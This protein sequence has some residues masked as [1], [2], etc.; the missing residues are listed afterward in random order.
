MYLNKFNEL[1][2]LD[3]YTDVEFKARVMKL[4]YRKEYDNLVICIFDGH[5]KERFIC[6]NGISVLQKELKQNCLY[7][8]YGVARGRNR[9]YFHLTS[10]SEVA[11][12]YNE[13]FKYFPENFN[14]VTNKAKFI[15]DTSI[16]KIQDFSIRGLVA[17]CLG[18]VVDLNP[19][20]PE[21]IKK[22][23]LYSNSP[24]SINYHDNYRG[25]YIV[26]IAGML[27]IADNL[28]N[29]YTPGKSY[30]LIT[31]N[32]IDF[33]LLR[34]LIY[35]HDCGKP[36]TYKEVNGSFTWKEDTILSHEQLGAQIVLQSNYSKK[37]A[38]VKLQKIIKGILEHMTP[39]RS[40][41]S[42]INILKSIDSLESCFADVITRN[43]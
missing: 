20:S 32:N 13:E 4:T 30:R 17:E 2:E 29:V 42:E 5:T 16:A 40:N 11:I 39:T 18:L 15:Y 22:Y 27:D 10:F 28:E 6:Y 38:N 8:F 21:Q 36:Y 7:H 3:E 31:N 12:D 9:R 14:S 33:D 41:I 25:G 34:A 35:L 23:K 37:V 1:Y 43:D 19:E 24:A 26:H